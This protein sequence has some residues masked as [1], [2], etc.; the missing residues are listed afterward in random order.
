MAAYSLSVSCQT[1]NVVQN[2]VDRM[3]YTRKYHISECKRNTTLPPSVE[4]LICVKPLKPKP[5]SNAFHSC[6]LCT[7]ICPDAIDIL[8]NRHFDNKFRLLVVS[9]WT[10]I[11]LFNI[12]HNVRDGNYLKFRL[13][14]SR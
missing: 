5:I 9:S 10:V 3:S 12:I 14:G 6:K 11:Q 7:T 4:R 2:F 1:Y 8:C 13:P